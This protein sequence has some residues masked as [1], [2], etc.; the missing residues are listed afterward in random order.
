LAALDL[1][2]PPLIYGPLQG[3]PIRAPWDLSMLLPIAIAIGYWLLV[4]IQQKIGL[5]DILSLVLIRPWY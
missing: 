1:K 4:T 3:I 2:L 5:Y